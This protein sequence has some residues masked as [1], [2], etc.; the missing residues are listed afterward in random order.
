MP[1]ICVF[2]VNETLLDLA[3]LDTHFERIFGSATIRREWFSQLLQSAF[4]ATIV[5]EYH[6]FT[7]LGRAS[8]QMTAARHNV[9]L[10]DSDTVS[11]LDGM[12]RLP[13]HSDVEPAL[14]RLHDAEFRLATLSNSP[15]ATS[16]AQ[17]DHAGL[18]HHFER[19]LSAS[20]VR[21]LKPAPEPYHM[22]A[23]QLGV[24]VSEIRLIAAHS[25]DVT[26]AIH[27]GCAAAFVSRAGARFDPAFQ[28]PDITGTS[29]VDVA[30]QI[31]AA[32]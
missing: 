30:E 20:T 19:V 15:P 4:T 8:L 9:A 11:I 2:D 29:L 7:V 18:R 10:S 16:E 31:V 1:S 27:A 26:G 28:A 23:E 21:R 3:A 5:D 32:G 17:I 6:D 24:A 12:K 25:W 14:H 22:A 13:A